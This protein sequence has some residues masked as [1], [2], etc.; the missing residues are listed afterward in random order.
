MENEEITKGEGI[1]PP[2]ALL[3][4]VGAASGLK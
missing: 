3:D 2:L 1:R 4:F